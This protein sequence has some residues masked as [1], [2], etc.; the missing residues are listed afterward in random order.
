MK[1]LITEPDFYND[2]L[3]NQCPREWQITKLNIVSNMKILY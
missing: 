1:V 3:L 2:K